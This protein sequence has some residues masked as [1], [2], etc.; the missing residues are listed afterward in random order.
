MRVLLQRRRHVPARVVNN[1]LRRDR[2]GHG[3]NRRGQHDSLDARAGAGLDEVGHHGD[4]AVHATADAVH[5]GFLLLGQRVPHRARRRR[6]RVDNKVAAYSRVKSNQSA[7]PEADTRIQNGARTLDGHV[8]R[9]GRQKRRLHDREV[10]VGVGELQQAGDV[11]LAVLHRAAHVVAAVQQLAHDPRGQ[12]AVHARD[13]DGLVAEVRGELHDLL[14]ELQLLPDGRV[15]ALAV[16]G[17]LVL[18]LA[19]LL[20]AASARLGQQRGRAHGGDAVAVSIGVVGVGS[21]QARVVEVAVAAR[22]LVGQQIR[23]GGGRRVGRVERLRGAAL[24]RGEDGGGRAGH[25]GAARGCRAPCRPCVPRRRRSSSCAGEAGFPPV[26]QIWYSA[27]TDSETRATAP[28]CDEQARGGTV[29]ARAR[30][31]LAG[32]AAASAAVNEKRSR[33]SAQ[34]NGET[35]ISGHDDSRA[36]SSSAHRCVTPIDR[37]VEQT[38]STAGMHLRLAAS[39]NHGRRADRSPPVVPYAGRFNLAEKVLGYIFCFAAMPSRELGPVPARISAQ[40]SASARR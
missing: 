6:P 13:A 18:L 40:I 15:H 30:I 33:P 17:A 22:A 4:D 28:R 36:P 14:A 23:H 2:V 20:G 12:E 38:V 7:P 5:A 26:P 19:L 24:A 10:L 21:V 27:E 31:A 35:D 1:R 8:A 25:A 29:G 39:G 37:A 9:L 11:V 32:A 16:H 34:W 3:S